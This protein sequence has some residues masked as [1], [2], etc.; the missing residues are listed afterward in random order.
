MSSEPIRIVIIDDTRI[1][2]ECLVSCI[3]HMK[4]LVVAGTAANGLE[5]IELVRELRPD[6]ALIDH[7]LSIASSLDIIKAL[8]NSFPE[9]PVIVLGLPENENIIISNIEAGIAGYILKDASIDHLLKTIQSV[10]QNEAICSPRITASLFSRLAALKNESSGQSNRILSSLTKREL[11]IATL[12][13]DGLR[14]KE[15]A[16]RLYIEIQ[17]VKNHIHNILEKLNMKNRDEITRY[18]HDSHIL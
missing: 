4:D 2:M 5:A 16:Q 8:H 7:S 10:Q 15:I 1:R 17:T 9:F 14:N 12:V 13:A 3:N 11:E 6:I 18:L